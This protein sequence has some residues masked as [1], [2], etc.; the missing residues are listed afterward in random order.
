MLMGMGGHA[1]H[2]T[3][4]ID[5][6]T[7]A[8]CTRLLR[9][10]TFPG[11][12]RIFSNKLRFVFRCIHDMCTEHAGLSTYVSY[13]CIFTY[14]LFSIELLLHNS[15]QTQDF[16]RNCFNRLHF[17]IY[18]YIFETNRAQNACVAPTWSSAMACALLFKWEKRKKLENFYD[19]LLCMCRFRFDNDIY[20]VIVCSLLATGNQSLCMVWRN[21]FSTE[22]IVCDSNDK[23][24]NFISRWWICKSPTATSQQMVSQFNK[25]QND[26][27]EE[28]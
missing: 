23:P 26:R 22:I 3:V 15:I 13:A 12:F 9:N 28:R 27:L 24:N 14:N 5:S 11:E 25:I 17:H 7:F 4:S 6:K 10:G 1:H 21:S 16:K 20:D 18:Y 8:S 2:H 19:L